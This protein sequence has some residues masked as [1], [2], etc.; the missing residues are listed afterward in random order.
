M[1]EP[2]QLPGTWIVDDSGKKYPGV[3]VVDTALKS[4]VLKV[5]FYGEKREDVEPFPADFSRPF[6]CG[7]LLSGKFVSLS[8]CVGS[9]QCGSS[10]AKSPR[11]TSE[12]HIKAKYAF[13]NVFV[14]DAAQ[15][16][17]RGALVDFGDIGEWSALSEVSY[18]MEPSEANTY[19][20]HLKSSFGSQIELRKGV[21][22]F[23]SAGIRGGKT[24]DSSSRVVIEQP[25]Y[26]QFYY[27]ELQSWDRIMD[28]IENVR[29]LIAF[30]VGRHVPIEKVQT[31]HESMLP[32]QLRGTSSFYSSFLEEVYLGTERVDYP[33]RNQSETITLG[34]A[35]LVS[36]LS[37]DVELGW[38]RIVYARSVISLF[39]EAHVYTDRMHFEKVFLILARAIE[40]AHRSLDLLNGGKGKQVC[41]DT[42]LRDLLTPLCAVSGMGLDAKGFE[43]KISQIKDTR[44]YYTH[45]DPELYERALHDEPL[46]KLADV[47]NRAVRFYILKLL[48]CEDA[49][50]FGRLGYGIGGAPKCEVVSESFA[51]GPGDVRLRRP[52][53]DD[54]VR[55]T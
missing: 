5:W 49:D 18:S 21:T 32:S 4:V 2:L 10:N 24:K 45:Y 6:V 41:F 13:V 43:E 34:L 35:D 29:G 22:V 39:L 37:P 25:T 20:W 17:F 7:R 31:V 44:N 26:V 53:L 36:M 54:D 30:G 15:L 28:D 47:L 8:A 51:R 55:E 9:L 27:Q 46:S 11:Y 23:F 48:G 50:A 52:A 33:K 42:R 16:S 3:L 19:D 40:A 1:S 14:N 12:Y 38:R